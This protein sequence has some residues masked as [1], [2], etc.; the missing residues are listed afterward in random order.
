MPR[1]LSRISLAFVVLL[2]SEVWAL[3]L[4]EIQLESALNEPLRAEI[5]LLS[6][7]P[8]EVANLKIGLASSETFDR[9]GLD[10]PVYL[11]N[12]QFQ[13][14]AAGGTG[15]Y[16]VELRSGEPMTEPFLTFLIEA[17]WTR[18]RLLR[19]YTVLLDPPTFAPPAAAQSTAPVTAPSRSEPADSNR[20]ERP[21]PAQP[22]APAQTSRPAP[23][24]PRPQPAPS[25]PQPAVDD[26][27]YD[28]T[29]AGNYDVRRGDTLWD[30]ARSN[31]PD[32]RLT[33]NQVMVAIFERNQNAFGG[34]INMLQAGSTL[35]IPSAD[36]IF[37][38]SRG[39]ASTEVQRQNVA[40]GS[41]TEP[42]DAATT[43]PSLTLVPPDEDYAADQPGA[44]ATAADTSYGDAPA[45]REQDI[46]QRIADLEA[47]DVPQQRSLI[48]I[49][50]N[51][52]AALREELARIRGEVYVPPVEDPGAQV[53]DD[54]LQDE[55]AIDADEVM[56]DSA[57]DAPA[58]V[59]AEQAIAD[60]DSEPEAAVEP[61]P[62]PLQRQAKPTLLDQVI[63]FL[64]NFWTILVAAIAVIGGVV[65]WL[66]RR[67]RS[68]AEESG[69]WESLDDD[70]HS[71]DEFAATEQLSAPV[72]RDESFVVVEQEPGFDSE[73]DQTVEA[74]VPDFDIDG[75]D[76]AIE[77]DTIVEAESAL[78]ESA[79]GTD[80][81]VERS[82][83][84]TDTIVEADSTDQFGSLEDTFS[85]E[86]AVNLDQSDPMAEADFHMAYGLYDQAAELINGALEGEPER[87]DLLTKL[88]E[89]YFVWG[90]RDAF[91]DAAE[92]VKS[93]A[94]DGESG[95]WNKILIMGQQIAGDHE[96]FA[97]GAVAGATK[98]VDLA[99][100]AG[101][102][103]GGTLD[104]ELFADAMPDE[105][106]LDL[107]AADDSDTVGDVDFDF[108]SDAGQAS[109]ATDIDFDPTVEAFLG[110]MAEKEADIDSTAEMT[111]AESTVEMPTI[112]QPFDS[113]VS[114]AE[115]TTIDE[116][117]L[118]VSEASADATAEINLDD[119]GLDLG[120]LDVSKITGLDDFDETEFA[121]LDEL[122]QTGTGGEADS[123]DDGDNAA[124]GDWDVDV[125]LTGR[126]PGSFADETGINEVSG[127]DADTTKVANDVD[128]DR[129]LL[130][131]TGM[132]QVL[133][134]DDAVDTDPEASEVIGHDDATMLA[135]GYG[136]GTAAASGD[137]DKTM[138]ADLDGDDDE[139]DYAR[140]ESFS[141]DEIAPAL[142]ADETGELPALGSTN[143]ELD[144]DDLTAALEVSQIGDSFLEVPDDDTVEQKRPGA[145]TDDGETVESLALN[146]QASSDAL[147]EARTMTEVGTKLD[148]ARAYVDMGDPAGARSIL[149]EVLDEGSE[150]Q[151]QQAQ[152]L[153]DSLPS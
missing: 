142:S 101:A 57:D 44:D 79:S 139:F 140:T 31:R 33:T 32:D 128:I 73:F 87:E 110:D 113:L 116:D 123:S 53:S 40:W 75:T 80:T 9:Y 103:E 71:D 136:G 124:L 91:I 83:A 23:S 141:T 63:G 59:D 45:T 153:L 117:T 16:V 65:F 98:V 43:R 12:I 137:D 145:E 60:A 24:Q 27:P 131:A 132:T 37:R 148:L 107:G 89:I 54:S 78:E 39:Q 130:D 108:D 99:F 86:A 74:L 104:M 77:A 2:S 76:T 20:I 13:V 41:G 25:Q 11:Q 56:T 8:E 61:A 118:G 68:D 93:V 3:G 46:E 134:S 62:V 105:D 88:C 22:A 122:E 151:R 35:R 102:D 51:E 47:A 90:N 149:E 18:G 95:E 48:E 114:T 147:Y 144:L 6:A 36:E 66:M 115:M 92:R 81:L 64:T 52:L 4:G 96:L 143:V 19:E 67:P 129:R 121:A 138:F 7:T 84:A 1:I 38:I 72:P 112:E 5:E 82:T 34:N 69:V 125:D 50:D 14:S 28:T 21:A 100:D 10:R 97:G 150:G 127:I 126:H 17:S 26:A 109:D 15:G 146:P 58:A 30:I 49:R 29:A 106:V 42:A 70:E 55:A 94:G 135:P 111:P 152:H 85:T 133:S 119:L 120:G